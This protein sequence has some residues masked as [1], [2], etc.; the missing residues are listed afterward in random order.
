VAIEYELYKNIRDIDVCTEFDIFQVK[1]HII[2]LG[3]VGFSLRSGGRYLEAGDEG[4]TVPHVHAAAYAPHTDYSNYT[5]TSHK[6]PQCAP[7]P[8]QHHGVSLP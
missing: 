3:T 2:F 8:L 5:W 1:V 7:S 4:Y 6:S